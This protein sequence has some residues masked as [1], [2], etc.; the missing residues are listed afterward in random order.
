MDKLGII[1][2]YGLSET[3]NI[4]PFKSSQINQLTHELNGIENIIKSMN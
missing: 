4:K 1:T 2:S 3:R